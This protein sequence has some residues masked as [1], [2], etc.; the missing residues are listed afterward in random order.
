MFLFELTRVWQGR[1]SE[2]AKKATPQ[3]EIELEFKGQLG[4]R[5]NWNIAQQVK[6]SGF[7]YWWLRLTGLYTEWE[8][9]ASEAKMVA[10]L[11]ELKHQYNKQFPKGKMVVVNFL[12]NPFV[13]P[14]LDDESFK[15][16]L[17]A[18]GIV[19]WQSYYKTNDWK[20]LSIPF[21]GHPTPKG[22]EI[23]AERLL[24]A[25]SEYFRN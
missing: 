18:E 10:Y 1:T 15:K 4:E 20:S 3:F 8:R 11:R 2:L 25:G 9:S 23:Q 14:Y 21:D 6:R 7:Q 17:A 13:A 16:K 24:I 19:I 5:M 22:H 12:N